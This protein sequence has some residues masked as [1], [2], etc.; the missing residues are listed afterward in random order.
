MNDAIQK[1]ANTDDAADV[2]TQVQ[3]VYLNLVAMNAIIEK[4]YRE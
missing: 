4:K 3:S 2:P 1:E